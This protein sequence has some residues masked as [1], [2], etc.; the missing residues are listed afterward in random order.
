MFR[1]FPHPGLNGRPPA[2]NTLG[3]TDISAIFRIRD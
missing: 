2:T 1:D 3:S